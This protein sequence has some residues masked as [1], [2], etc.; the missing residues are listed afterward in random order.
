M[1]AREILLGGKKRA[2][3]IIESD[4]ES[5]STADVMKYRPEYDAYAA[6]EQASSR[7]PKS[8]VE[9]MRERK[10]QDKRARK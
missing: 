10:A 4:D 1:P 8:P 6:D 7:E 3:D 5:L 2:R 9:F